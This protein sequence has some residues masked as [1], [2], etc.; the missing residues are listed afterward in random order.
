[1]EKLSA[2]QA[3]FKNQLPDRMT[4]I[5]ALWDE[6]CVSKQLK[7][8][9]IEQ[10]YREVHSLAGAGGTFG[11]MN[12]STVARELE[13]LIQILQAETADELLDKDIEHI[14]IALEK[15]DVA[16]QRWQPSAIPYVKPTKVP[17][18]RHHSLIYVVEDDVLLADE[19]CRHL[20]AAGYQ[21]RR[22]NQLDDFKTAC[23]RQLP[24]AIIMDMVFEEGGCAGAETIS[25]LKQQF[26]TFPHVIFISV[27]GDMQA[28]LQAARAGATRYFT[29][30]LD[31][32][33]LINVLDKI[34]DRLPDKPYRILIVDDDENL[35]E[36]YATVL[37][38]AGML[39]RTLGDPMDAIAVI[40]EFKPELTILDIN[41]PQCSGTELAQVIRQDDTM[42]HMPITFLSTDHALD[43]QLAAL[44][45]GGDDFLSKPITAWHLE[46]AIKVRVRRSRA[47]KTLNQD[48]EQ[49]LRES[50]YRRIALDQHSIVSIT[51]AEG[52]ITAVNEKFCQCSGYTREELIG[53]DHRLLSSGEHSAEYFQH[54]W[55]R[56]RQ[57]QV[58]HGEICNHDKQGNEFWIEMTVVPFMKADNSAPYQ[59]VAV[60]SDITR[61]MKTQKALTRAKDEAEKANLSKSR[62]LSSMSHELRTPL[63]AIIG[64][65]QLL[66]VNSLENLTEDQLEDVSHIHAAGNHLLQLINEVLDLS[67]IEA[68]KFDLYIESVS[69]VHVLKDCMNLVLPMTEPKKISLQFIDQGQA[70]SMDQ[71]W[72]KDYVLKGDS[73]RLKQ[74]LLNLLTNAVKYNVDGGSIELVFEPMEIRA[75]SQAQ[76]WTQGARKALRIE[77]R[78]TGIGIAPQVQSQLFKPF[79]RLGAEHTDVEGTGIGLVITKNL[80][81]LMAGT[82]GY[83]SEPGGGSR[84]WVELPLESC[85][86]TK[87]RGKTAPPDEAAAEV[88]EN[89][90]TIVYI[91]DNLANLRLMEQFLKSDP[92]VRLLTA[93]QP[94]KGMELIDKHKPGLVLLDINLPEITG[95]DVLKM[96]RSQDSTRN[97][98][99]VAISA[100]AMPSDFEKGRAAGFDDY[101]AKPIDISELAL[102][103]KKYAGRSMVTPAP[104]PK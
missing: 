10:L 45:L 87:S 2:L 43:R 78:D 88:S 75:G 54:L 38:E 24:T 4:A 29:K 13:N 5:V 8:C 93:A 34:T 60:S 91:E 77:V 68:G 14:G 39:V 36:F 98:P 30:P 102:I 86:S 23:L 76:Q 55:Q 50:E 12:I 16:V 69:L 94:S 104:A 79:Q 19:I 58:W 21:V 56:I 65:S 63:N 57:G 84:F 53:Q 82:I 81:E 41:M 52:K 100:N 35:R 17:D 99:V 80:V 42:A 33:A 25:R 48:L 61:L 64:F 89:L 1:M 20:E 62:F 66:A 51:D 27:R 96:L 3:D 31:N 46:E 67:K 26:E 74:V 59:Y 72:Q 97:I 83:A 32:N 11:A 95:Y 7:A 103:L 44:H 85:L 47:M 15:L 6:L 28:R 92:A 37:T 90:Q 18:H 71:F 70:V 22:F 9:T 40:N 49:A 73:T 101:L